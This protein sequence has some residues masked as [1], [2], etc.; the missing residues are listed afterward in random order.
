MGSKYGIF[1]YTYHKFE[2]ENAGKYTSPMDP[3][4]THNGLPN[5]KKRHGNLRLA[6][7]NG[8]LGSVITGRD[9]APEHR[10]LEEGSEQNVMGRH[11]GWKNANLVDYFQG[12][13]ASKLGLIFDY[14]FEKD[15][16]TNK[17]QM[18][19]CSPFQTG[20]HIVAEVLH[21]FGFGGQYFLFSLLATFF[22]SRFS[23]FTHLMNWIFQIVFSDGLVKK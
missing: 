11:H 4:W 18:R 12:A 3:C 13:F 17:A 5:Q 22:I 10:T 8:W 19:K 15:L 23:R 21:P 20:D 2:P 6:Y 7:S 1:T 14:I 16:K 9:P